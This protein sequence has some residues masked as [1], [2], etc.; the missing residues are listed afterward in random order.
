M[1]LLPQNQRDQIMVFVV[2]VAVAAMGLYYQYVW[3]PKQ[4]IL[5]T[6]EA[7]VERLTE[8]NEKI[9]REVKRGNLAKLKA[10]GERYRRDLAL[11]RQLV[12]TRNEVPALL[13][14]VSTA[15]RRVGLDLSDV[16][17]EDVVIGVHFD[18]HR[19][20][21]GVNGDYHAIARFLTNVGSLTRIVAPINLQLAPSSK[22]LPRVLPK[23]HRL[24]E[25][26]LQ[27]QTYVAR[28]GGIP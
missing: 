12:P 15:A 26:R 28:G 8:L 4:E 6:L 22:A 2:I 17:P 21:I 25:A 13:E 19:Y 18:V 27:I 16:Q 5:A 23:Q 10:E 11:L 7:R 20:R 3:S 9:E 1:A 14:Q 24:L